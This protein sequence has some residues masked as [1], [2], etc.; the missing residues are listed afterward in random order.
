VPD[1]IYRRGAGSDNPIEAQK[2]VERVIYHAEHHPNLTVGVVA[3][4]EAQA[5]CIQ[6]QLEAVRRERRDLDDLLSREPVGRILH[7][8]PGIGAR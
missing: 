7:Q 5:T 6:Y 3:F 8:E 4:S 2:V 1:G